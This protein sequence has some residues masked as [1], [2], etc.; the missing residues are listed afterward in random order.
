[1]C[2]VLNSSVLPRR[3]VLRRL[4][5]AEL[6]KDIGAGQVLKTPLPSIPGTHEPRSVSSL[7]IDADDSAE[8]KRPRPCV[9]RVEHVEPR[10]LAF[11]ATEDC[12]ES[13][14]VK[15]TSGLPALG[16]PPTS[17]QVQEKQCC[18]APLTHEASDPNS[19]EHIG[20]PSASAIANATFGIVSK[21]EP[22]LE[23]PKMVNAPMAAPTKLS[24]LGVTAIVPKKLSQ[25]SISAM[26]KRVERSDYLDHQRQACAKAARAADH[27]NDWYRPTADRSSPH[28]HAI[29]AGLESCYHRCSA[30]DGEGELL[31]CDGCENAYHGRCLNPPL[32]P[33]E[34]ADS[35]K[36]FCPE[37]VSVRQG[38][39][40]SH[41]RGKRQPGRSMDDSD[42]IEAKVGEQV[43][44]A[45]QQPAQLSFG[46]N[47]LPNRC[48][49]TGR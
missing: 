45:S 49:F 41:V 46:R 10:H 1:V 48:A 42:V 7:H 18:A 8:H 39:S 9:D 32:N 34:L 31:C 44:S 14:E 35:A 5:A 37:C 40:Q 43:R 12:L 28:V 17:S 16:R 38:S 21:T 19:A 4:D 22:S 2:S 13:M 24:L 47:R 3:Y 25:L 27:N 15:P 29:A 30:C 23:A 26:F 36:W 11:N 33:K 6:A 20:K